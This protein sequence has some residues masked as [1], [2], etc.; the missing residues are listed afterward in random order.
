VRRDRNGKEE[1]GDGD[2]QGAEYEDVITPDPR[3]NVCC[4]EGNE[5][6]GNACGDEA[7]GCLQRAKALIFL[8]TEVGRLERSALSRE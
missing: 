6:A 5:D 4:Y 7:E 3:E 8:E 1:G 2:R